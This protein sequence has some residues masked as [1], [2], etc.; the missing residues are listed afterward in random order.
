M[1]GRYRHEDK[2]YGLQAALSFAIRQKALGDDRFLIHGKRADSHPSLAMLTRDGSLAL[3]MVCNN[4]N[5][6]REVVE[7]LCQVLVYA[8]KYAELSL[9]QLATYYCQSR[10]E[11]VTGFSFRGASRPQCKSTDPFVHQLERYH[12]ETLQTYLDASEDP[13]QALELLSEDFRA[14][15]DGPLSP[16][17]NSTSPVI[18][19]M[20]IARH[21][22]DEAKATFEES[23]S[24]LSST[25]LA[26][27]GNGDFAPRVRESSTLAMSLG[28][29]SLAAKRVQPQ[30]WIQDVD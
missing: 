21:W 13:K 26:D 20:V 24:G 29:Y 17:G 6:R 16:S 30:T 7:K 9:Q 19:L 28:Q 12:P 8:T 27:G 1:T 25:L 14:W 15:N 10:V 2:V 5:T 11:S 4:L 22:S 23:R 3:G 18:E